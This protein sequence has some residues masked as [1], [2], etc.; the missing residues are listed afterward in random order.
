MGSVK[1]YDK[2]RDNLRL[3]ILGFASN[4]LAE[5]GD[6]D[7]DYENDYNDWNEIARAYMLYLKNLPSFNPKWS[8]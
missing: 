5:L 6:D 8:A 2:T 1:Q 4:K 7:D 3:L